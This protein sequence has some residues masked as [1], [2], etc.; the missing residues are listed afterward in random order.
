[1]R[2]ES[3]IHGVQTII[4]NEVSGGSIYFAD[5]STG[6]PADVLNHG[7]NVQGVV[8]WDPTW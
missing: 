6:D 3:E 1:M 5:D 4:G 2:V 8:V 7:N